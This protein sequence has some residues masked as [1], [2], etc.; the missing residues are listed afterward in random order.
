[1]KKK[2]IFHNSRHWEL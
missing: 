2:K 1:M